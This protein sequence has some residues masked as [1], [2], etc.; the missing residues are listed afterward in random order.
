[1]QTEQKNA[2]FLTVYSIR[3]WTIWMI[4]AVPKLKISLM[5]TCGFTRVTHLDARPN[6]TVQ[7]ARQNCLT[8]G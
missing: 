5:K 6:F 2:R 8:T 4:M 1:M 3:M 7:S